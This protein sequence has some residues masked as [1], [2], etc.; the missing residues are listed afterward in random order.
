MIIN[1]NNPYP[2][3][4]KGQQL[5]SSSLAG[6]VTFA[7]DEDKATR[8]YLEGSGI[9]YGLN[10]EVNPA[11]GT[12][13]LFPGTA[14]TSDGYLFALEKE[15]V[16]DGISKK[17][18]KDF[19]IE[20]FERTAIIKVLN[21]KNDNNRELIHRLS[22]VDP[23]EPPLQLPNDTTP[24]LIVLITLDDETT[25]QSCLYGYENNE[26]KKNKKVYPALI[27]KSF[28]QPGELE[29]WYIGSVADAGDKDPVVNRFGYTDKEEGGAHISFNR[30]TSWDPFHTG[31]DEVCTAAELLI[32]DAFKAVYDLVKSKLGL[33]T[34]NPFEDL[35][36]NLQGL[37]ERVRKG[38]GRKY[39]WL[40]DYYR[41]LVAAYQEFVSTDMFSYLSYIP[42]KDRFPGYISLG[43]VR[44]GSDA[45]PYRMGLY[46][47]PFADLSFNALE[48]PKLLM[49]RLMYLADVANTRFDETGFP[50]REVFFTPDAGLN[51][52]L[53]DRAI[54]FYYKNPSALSESWNV[55]LTRSRRT[56]DIPG[57]K[58]EQDRKFL[59]T[60]MEN[61]N[62]FRIK[63][64]TGDTIDTTQTAIEKLRRD[65]HLPFDLKFVYLGT[66]ADMGPLISERSA[67]FSDLTILLEKIVNDIRCART[68]SDNFERNIFRDGFDRDQIG[69]MFEELV[70]FFDKPPAD[71][72][73]KLDQLC[74]GDGICNDEDKTC[75]RAHL[76]SLY[77]VYDEYVGRKKELL[78][79]LLFHLFAEKHP[80]LEHN[81]GVPKGGTL[82][83]LCA[84]NDVASL[85][86]ERKSSLV[87]LLLSS[88]EEEKAAAISLARELE[89]YNIVADFS[90]PYICCSGKPAINLVLQDAPPVA[91]FDITDQDE[92]PEGV[93]VKVVLK[94][95]SLR[96]DTYHWELYDFKGEFIT[97]KHTNNL[98][99]VVEFDL[100]RERGVV[101]A[102]LLTAS[103]EGMDSK[104]STEIVICPKGEVSVTVNGKDNIDLDISDSNEVEIAVKPY[105]GRFTLVLQ[106]NDNQE[107][108]DPSG[109]DIDW[110]EDKTNAILTIYDPQTG[111]YTLEY[112][113]NVKGCEG[114]AGK[115]TI[116]A[117]TPAAKE[118]VNKDIVPG[119]DNKA[120]A[121]N[122][123]VL[124]K[125]ILGYRG[126]VNKM[127]KEDE[128][129]LEDSRWADTKTFLLA[130]GAPEVLHA[131]YEKLQT[132]L[133]TGFSKLK[134][135]QKA[136]V[137]RMLVYA[138]AYYVDRLIV[139]SPDKVPAIAR[140]LVKA[141][142]ESI[143]AQK[144]GVAQ[145][146]QVW[147]TTGIVTEENEKT[148]NTYKGLIA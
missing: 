55:G 18:E 109:F 131:A 6:I 28:F 69:N 126:D 39:P 70:S 78:D 128:A 107:D 122:D 37:N 53:S 15:V 118:P 7:E 85:S 106:Q 32:G 57:I 35:T 88:K 80:G 102:V 144:D 142:A 123:A 140:K 10:I 74:G 89:G 59:T 52:Q 22:G 79:G 68:C 137:I 84:K 90:L 136:Q 40:Y 48:R 101:F 61:Y 94:N 110:K 120:V 64:H 98:N 20:L 119:A 134:V 141:A 82:V 66:E 21:D 146:Q 2:L 124:N 43:S 97:D 14:V 130:S 75:C 41:D 73:E 76:T 93:G 105:G 65:L 38:G 115:L 47:P 86:E 114:A 17:A 148:V 26:S 95:Q 3:F 36:T 23:V 25:V 99:E 91:R 54:P 16:Y 4:K 49:K 121:N 29:E 60:N 56:F 19:E 113:F 63:G 51:R 5:K 67:A 42:K 116:N 8:M 13:K 100:M 138:T 96:A 112:R 92:L 24:Y 1:E 125:R 135:A 50:P 31:F 62:F 111:I 71:L 87:N 45:K 34:A 33:G 143:A 46:R 27:P 127:A 11:A 108:I 117:R 12:V 103:R 104:Y 139:S 129:L 30:F 133:Q 9:F 58:E 81:G 44:L 145:W 132:N 72:D 77:A 147:N 83:L